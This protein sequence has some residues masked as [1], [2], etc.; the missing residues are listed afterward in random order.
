MDKSPF[1]IVLSL[2]VCPALSGPLGALKFTPRKA[3]DI[4]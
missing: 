3:F 1:L 4:E 2:F